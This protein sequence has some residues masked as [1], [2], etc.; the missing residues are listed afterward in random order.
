[1]EL[2]KRRLITSISKMR[3]KS[4]ENMKFHLITDLEAKKILSETVLI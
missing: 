1:M 3:R 4:K 2:N